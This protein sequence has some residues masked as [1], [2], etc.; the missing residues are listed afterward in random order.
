MSLYAASRLPPLSKQTYG[1]GQAAAAVEVPTA[2]VMLY[3]P[4]VAAVPGRR[5]PAE[6]RAR[7]G[8]CGDAGAETSGPGS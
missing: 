8:Q 1:Q 7:E 2:A 4:F 6:C 5:D 3:A